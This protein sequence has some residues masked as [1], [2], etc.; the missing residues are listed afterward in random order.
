MS[1]DVVSETTQKARKEYTCADCAQPIEVGRKYFRQ[2]MVDG[3]DNWTHKTHVDCNEA[4]WDIYRWFDL[5]YG[6]DWQGLA[7]A[8]A[9]D[10][11]C[12]QDIAKFLRR[13]PKYLA[14]RRRMILTRLEW[15]KNRQEYN[16]R[17]RTVLSLKGGAL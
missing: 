11:D 9:E 16:Q 5:T 13:N 10:R 1:A 3:G 15:R 14:V 12:A 7:H 2:F 17:V 8:S 6:D 4:S